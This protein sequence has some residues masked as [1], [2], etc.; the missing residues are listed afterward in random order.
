MYEVSELYKYKNQIMSHFGNPKVEI[1]APPPPF[2]SLMK[3]RI[4]TPT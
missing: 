3:I 1:L 4:V 2:F